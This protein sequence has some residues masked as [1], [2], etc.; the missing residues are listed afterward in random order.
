MLK[1][2]NHL[3]PTKQHNSLVVLPPLA[4][5]LAFDVVVTDFTVIIS[6]GTPSS[7]AHTCATFNTDEYTLFCNFLTSGIKFI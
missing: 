2:H 6:I 1:Y 3:T 7:N 5:S 4:K